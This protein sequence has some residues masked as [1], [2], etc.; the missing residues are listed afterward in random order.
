MDRRGWGSDSRLAPGWWQGH[1]LA[2]S[3]PKPSIRQS[4][5]SA[6]ADAALGAEIERII[7]MTIEERVMAA[8]TLRERFDWLQP[9]A[10]KRFSP[11]K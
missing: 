8:L 4:R 10:G 5:R 1:S 9:A 7:R 2:M 3:G 6:C 11:E